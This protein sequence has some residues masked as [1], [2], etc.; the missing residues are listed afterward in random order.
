VRRT[1][2]RRGGAGASPGAPGDGGR[3]SRK[4]RRRTAACTAPLEAP[5]PELPV[6]GHQHH[7]R[8]RGGKGSK[9]LSCNSNA[10]WLER[11]D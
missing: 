3:G 5:A 4:S 10:D 11:V 1:W 2:R 7:E 6:D 9:G 8:R